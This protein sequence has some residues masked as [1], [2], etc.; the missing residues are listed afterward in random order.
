VN[1]TLEKLEAICKPHNV[2]FQY[3]NSF[4][5][6][7]IYF[8]A[9]PKKCWVGSTT[10]VLYFHAENIRKVISF[11][12]RELADGFFDADTETLRETGQLEE[13]GE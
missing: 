4:G 1:K 6:W 2:E 12:E 13:G 3:D 11:I 8:D 7:N 5:D 9:P 10:T